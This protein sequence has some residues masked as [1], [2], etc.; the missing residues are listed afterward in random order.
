M[1]YEVNIKLQ[2]SLIKANSLSVHGVHESMNYLAIFTLLQNLQSI[3]K[4]YYNS[5]I[6]SKNIL[7]VFRCYLDTSIIYTTYLDSTY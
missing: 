2:P 4:G 6:V 5:Q 1:N 7:A 3:K